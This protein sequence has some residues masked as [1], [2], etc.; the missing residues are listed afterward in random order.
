VQF[1]LDTKAHANY[2]SKTTRNAG[3]SIS[4]RLLPIA[5]PGYFA[6]KTDIKKALVVV[7][8]N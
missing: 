4:A 2:M 3:S 6:S 7:A 1:F 5:I 8:G